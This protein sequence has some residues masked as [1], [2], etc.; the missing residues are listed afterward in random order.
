MEERHDENF[1]R[2]TSNRA[3]AVNGYS[4]MRPSTG[5]SAPWLSNSFIFESSNCLRAT[6]SQRS[7]FTHDRAREEIFTAL[8][9]LP[10]E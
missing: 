10:R 7:L 4:N 5:I 1:Y 6:L 3:K 9:L 2:L 8:P